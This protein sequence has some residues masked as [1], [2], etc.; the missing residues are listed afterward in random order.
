MSTEDPTPLSHGVT[1]QA[2]GG[3][4]LQIT[5]RARSIQLELALNKSPYGCAWSAIG[6]YLFDFGAGTS[7][8][9]TLAVSTFQI[10]FLE[11]LLLEIDGSQ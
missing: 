5:D 3:Y 8:P 11:T 6:D 7:V 1:L 10:M 2:P 9:P 4:C